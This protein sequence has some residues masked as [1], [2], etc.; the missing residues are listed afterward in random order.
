[1]ITDED[2]KKKCNILVKKYIKCLYKNKKPYNCYDIL[3]FTSR[4]KCY[5]FTN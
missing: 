4:I 2:L 1:M 3:Y 5:N